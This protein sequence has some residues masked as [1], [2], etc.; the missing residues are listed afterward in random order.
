MPKY[1]NVTFIGGGWNGA[2]S[3]NGDGIKLNVYCDNEYWTFSNSTIT[4]VKPFT[5]RIFF[6]QGIRNASYVRGRRSMYLTGDVDTDFLETTVGGEIFA[7]VVHKFDVG[8]SVKAWQQ[9]TTSGQ[10]IGLALILE[11]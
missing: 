3:G 8:D 5:A 9:N 2:N 7:T 11:I 4:C 10:T 6:V 1:K